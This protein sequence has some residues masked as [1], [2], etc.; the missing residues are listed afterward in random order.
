[1]SKNRG[2]SAIHR[3]GPKFKLTAAKYPLPKPVPRDQ[4]PEPAKTPKHGLWG[5]FPKSRETLSTPESDGEHGRPWAIP[6]LREKSWEDLHRLWWVCVKERNRIATSNY[7]RARLMAG[8]GD[9][10]ADVRDKAV[11][12]TMRAIKHVLRERWYA[13]EE[14]KRLYEKGVRPD[15]EVFEE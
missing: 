11:L 9:H 6:E 5:F 13:W 4:L 15:A 8:Y 10:E 14:A 12:T 1:M 7:E 2:V 3:T